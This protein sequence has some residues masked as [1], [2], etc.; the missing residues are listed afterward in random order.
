MKTTLKT[1]LDESSIL[2]QTSDENIIN[3]L[4]ERII[5]ESYETLPT[6]RKN[7]ILACAMLDKNFLAKM[8]KIKNQL[9]K[10]EKQALRL[11]IADCIINR[12][13]LK[14]IIEEII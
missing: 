12:R 5:L 3:Y 13:S 10:F 7:G 4:S 9:N 6:A 2:H 14:T 11:L 8:E 1:G